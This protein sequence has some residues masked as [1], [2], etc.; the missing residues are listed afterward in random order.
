[1][2]GWSLFG[3]GKVVEA[4]ITAAAESYRQKADG[5]MAVVWKMGTITAAVEYYRL[6]K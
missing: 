4:N 5:G 2:K 6:F 3:K 1:M